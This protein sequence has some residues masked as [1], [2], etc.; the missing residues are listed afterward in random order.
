[1]LGKQTKTLPNCATQQTLKELATCFP[2][3]G[4]RV[5]IVLRHIPFSP[6]VVSD[7]RNTVRAWF[8]LCRALFGC[9][10]VLWAPLAET[11]STQSFCTIDSWFERGVWWVCT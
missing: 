5:G 4:P 2:L 1:M 7:A 10:V 9:V 6:G 8:F 3:V 11:K